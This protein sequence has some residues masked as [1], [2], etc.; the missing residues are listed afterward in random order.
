MTSLTGALPSKGTVTLAPS[1]LKGRNRV[2]FYDIETTPMQSYHWQPKVE[3]IPHVMNKTDIFMLSW[4]AKWGGSD[5]M[6]A[7]HL[8]KKEVGRGDDRRIVGSLAD[9]IRQADTIIAHNGDRFDLPKVNARLLLTGGEPLSKVNT[10]DTLK[11]SRKYG[12]S[13]HKLDYL[14]EELLGEGKI[15]TDFS[16]WEDVLQGNTGAM[17]KM[18]EYNRHDV[19]LLERVY[20][21]LRRLS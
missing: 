5:E 1:P 10:V 21:A 6:T 2:L 14:A 15:R 13:Y 12:F 20:H 16:W 8:T 4:A 17:A 9:L 7:G 11:L 18:V 3:Y 19:V